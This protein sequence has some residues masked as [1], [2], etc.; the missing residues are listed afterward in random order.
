[1]KDMLLFTSKMNIRDLCIKDVH[2]NG[3]R[4]VF[5][6][7]DENGLGGRG[8]SDKMDVHFSGLFKI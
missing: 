7:V 1:M 4:G 6:I 8:V 2:L 3:G 5:E